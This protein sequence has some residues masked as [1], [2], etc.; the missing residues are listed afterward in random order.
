LFSFLEGKNGA[1]LLSLLP[2]YIYK[3][4]QLEHQNSTLHKL[5][6]E[7]MIKWGLPGLFLF[8]QKVGTRLYAL[9][10]A[11]RTSTCWWLNCTNWIW[12]GIFSG[13]CV[14]LTWFLIL[15]FVLILLYEH[16]FK[17]PKVQMQHK[18]GLS[19]NGVLYVT[20][21]TIKMDKRNTG[22]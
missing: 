12:I 4:L 6:D 10:A 13:A 15:Y 3:I 20:T 18:R 8:V 5:L 17:L 16:R 14:P 22:S 1:V 21:K 2:R 9:S 7:Q 11:S 19:T